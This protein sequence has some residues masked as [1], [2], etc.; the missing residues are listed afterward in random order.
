MNERTSP[1]IAKQL[2]TKA[3]ALLRDGRYHE[4]LGIL[5]QALQVSR[6]SISAS[7]VVD[8]TEVV[9]KAMDVDHSSR[10]QVLSFSGETRTYDSAFLQMFDGAFVFR[11]D[12]EEE[13]EGQRYLIPATILYNVG[14]CYHQIAIRHGDLS[15]GLSAAHRTYCHAMNVLQCYSNELH[16]SDMV[17]VAA[18]SNNL[19]S[20]F[21]TIM[22]DQ[23]AREFLKILEDTMEAAE[24]EAIVWDEDDCMVV[25]SMN[26]FLEKEL[27]MHALAPAA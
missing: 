20:I 14:L 11:N 10:L 17:L 12:S 26:L 13:Y 23:S 2:N 9:T 19:A 16:V 3:V 7:D 15:R 6:R 1:S 27:K 22:D 4:C 24:L 21:S 25:F 18:L 8:G 5:Q